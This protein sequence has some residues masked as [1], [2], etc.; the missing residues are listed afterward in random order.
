MQ[1]WPARGK[2]GG[3]K[4]REGREER[5]GEGG[6]GVEGRGG[7]EGEGERRWSSYIA[8]KNAAQ[9][10]EERNRTRCSTHDPSAASV[11]SPPSAPPPRAWTMQ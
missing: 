5:E 2:A 7:G 11:P 9:T 6:E 3:G 4:S 10:Q 1:E 8:T